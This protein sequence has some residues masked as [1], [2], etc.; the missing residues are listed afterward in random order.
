MDIVI[1]ILLI[2][3]LAGLFIFLMRWE[4]RVKRKYKQ[5][6]I[7]LLDM[8]DPNPAEVKETIKNLRLYTGKIKRDR[9][10]IGL[11]GSLQSK[12]GHLL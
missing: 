11:I 9:E 6:A 3:A 10:A 2:V 8:G 5:K 1:F 7:A 4:S 12:Y